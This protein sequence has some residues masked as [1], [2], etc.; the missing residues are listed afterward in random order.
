MRGSRMRYMHEHGS[1]HR[2]RSGHRARRGAIRGSVIRLLAERPMHGYELISEFE[3]RSG[4]RWR[5]SPGSVYP[6]LTQLEAEGLVRSTSE[7]GRRQFE[8][9]DQ[10]R[11]WFDEHQSE[12]SLPWE[13]WT[14]GGRGDLRRLGGEIL[15]QLRQ[16]GRYG[17]DTQLEKAAVILRRT[18]Q[19]LYELLA[20]TPDDDA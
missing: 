3:E 17:S 4:G 6:L 14:P 15:G 7:E 2:G 5:P 8:L 20:D 13:R 9:T 18:R 11:A 19:E 10:G 16:L 1:P 12:A